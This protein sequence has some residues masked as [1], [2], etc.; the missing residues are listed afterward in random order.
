MGKTATFD[1]NTKQFSVHNSQQTLR[2]TACKKFA[3]S[4][5]LCFPLVVSLTG[6]LVSVTVWAQPVVSDSEQ[7]AATLMSPAVPAIQAGLAYLAGQQV[8]DGSFATRGSGR[9]AAVC[10]LGGLAMLA[11]GSTPGRGPYG[12]QIDKVVDFLLEHT[13]PSGFIYVPDASL[14]GP[15]YGHGFATLFLAEVYGMSQRKDLREKLS[16]AVKLI[17]QTQNSEGGWR[18]EPVRADADL[19]VTIC[20]I[21]ALRAARNAGI[22]VPNQTIDL[23]IEYVKKSQSADGGFRY[24]LQSAG[25]RFPRSAAGVVAL[26]SAGIYEGNEIERGLAYLDGFLPLGGRPGQWG[27]FYYGQYYGV[28][29]MWQTGGERWQKWY[30]AARDVLLG[31]QRKNGSW[32]DSIGPQYATAMA[33][34]ILQTP[35]NVVPIFQR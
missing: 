21:M 2:F 6:W 3:A 25:S 14:H 26:Y 29:A 17:V 13:V 20:Q 5:W 24:T 32:N 16:S 10:G 8:E 12:G 7:S 27:H 35:N 23:C 9:N 19:S 34:I 4:H 15:M 1:S 31:L 11:S 33:C 18:Y 22:H 28:Q 30:P